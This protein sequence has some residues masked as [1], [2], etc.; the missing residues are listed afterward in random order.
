[1]GVDLCSSV[2]VS[3]RARGDGHC[4]RVLLQVH[5]TRAHSH[6]H[7]H[8]HTPRRRRYG[9]DGGPTFTASDYTRRRPSEYSII[10]F[11]RT[12]AHQRLPLHAVM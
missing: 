3:V 2:S 1:M 11:M 4:Q 12:H 7:T 6:T 10:S 9:I 8:T 5:K